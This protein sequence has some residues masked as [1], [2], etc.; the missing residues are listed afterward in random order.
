MAARFRKSIKVGGVRVNV[1]KKSVSVSAGGKGGRYTVNSS[2]RRTST[3][4]A[5]GTGLSWS[6]TSGGRHNPTSTRAANPS[7]APRPARTVPAQPVAPIKPGLFASKTAR[8]RYATES[9]LHEAMRNSLAHVNADIWM[10]KYDKVAADAQFGFA[11][12]VLGGLSGAT[13]RPPWAAE[14]LAA[15]LA[16]GAEPGTDPFIARYVSPAT[17]MQITFTGGVTVAMRLS[18]TLIGLT[19]AHLLQQ[20]GGLEDAAH[21]LDGLAGEP[22]V[23]LARAELAV[24]LVRPERALAETDA[25]ANVDDVSVL[26]LAARARAL[27]MLGHTEAA[28][29]VTKEGLRFPSRAPGARRQIRIV[30]GHVLLDAGKRVPARNEANR[31]LA[32]DSGAEGLTELLAR[33]DGSNADA[34]DR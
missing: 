22:A 23:C 29:E 15:A 16:A 28:L 19:L 20:A 34:S 17:S 11:A 9:L 33:L 5:P 2:G 1:N 30:R 26:M 31:V 14:H 21:A 6:A 4:S 32:E 18:R 12:H 24:D 7:P 27:R 13:V 3:V 25:V 8:A 10:P